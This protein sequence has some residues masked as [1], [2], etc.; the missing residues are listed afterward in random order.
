MRAALTLLCGLVMLR[1]ASTAPAKAMGR[2]ISKATE[3][4]AAGAP[5]EYVSDDGRKASPRLSLA[6][7]KFLREAPIEPSMVDV[8]AHDKELARGLNQLHSL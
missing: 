3:R 2:L 6:L 4:N 5:R 1:L 8:I 7:F